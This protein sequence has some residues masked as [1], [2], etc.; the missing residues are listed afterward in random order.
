MAN[1]E[2]DCRAVVDCM[3]VELVRSTTN[4]LYHLVTA[5]L[6]SPLTNVVLLKHRHAVLIHYLHGLDP[7]MIRT[8]GSVI[9]ANI[10]DLVTKQRAA[11]LEAETIL[12]S[13]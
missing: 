4:A 9:A 7:A 1:M 2:T 11:R 6:T 3:I 12:H 13:N 5:E 10:G 8:T